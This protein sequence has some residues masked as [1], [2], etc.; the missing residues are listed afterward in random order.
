MNKKFHF[1]LTLIVSS[2]F[3]FAQTPTWTW[4]KGATGT[5]TDEGYGVCTDSIGNI[6]ITGGFASPTITFGGF[7]LTNS[8]AFDIYLAK[9]NTSGNVL[10]AKSFGGPSGEFANYVA[11]DNSGNVYFTGGFCS[12]SITFGTYT[13]TNS[14][15][16]S[17]NVFVVKCDSSGNVKWAK[18]AGNSSGPQGLSIV[19]DNAGNAYVT[20]YFGV[21]SPITFG[22][23][24]LTNSGGQDCFLVKYNSFGNVVW[25]KAFGGTANDFGAGITTDNKCNIYLTGYYTSSSATFGT[26]LITNS[27]SGFEDAFIAKCDSSGN[28]LW[29]KTI[30]GANAERG[31]SI[32]NHNGIGYVSGYFSSSSMAIGNYTLTNSNSNQDVFIFKYDSIGNIRWAKGAGGNGIDYGFSVSADTSDNVYM[33]GRLSSSSITFGS[34]TLNAPTGNCNSACDPMFIVKYDSSGNVLCASTL[35]SG[36]DDQNCVSS[37]RYGNAYVTGDFLAISF[38]VGAD[39]LSLTGSENIFISKYSCVSTASVNSFGKKF[40]AKIYPNPTTTQF[41][42]EANTSQKLN[43]EL[44]DINCRHVFS[45]TVNDKESIN[46]ESLDNG[47]YTMTIKTSDGVINKKLVILR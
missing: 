5:G 30:G 44:F 47:S 14:N 43:I 13:L 24:T 10:W 42:I 15:S 16:P 9:Y 27:N 46:V 25:A 34:T 28:V 26:H 20:G 1:G 7:P 22:G 23:V 18:S 33:T 19:A 21:S 31:M 11:A 37:D 2:F 12:P 38:I 35:L 36:G 40:E 4:T 39:T 3:S 17:F 41:F 6:F 8:G 45:K 32:T 29:A